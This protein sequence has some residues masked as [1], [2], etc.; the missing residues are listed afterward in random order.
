MNN[1]EKP[2]TN[3]TGASEYGADDVAEADT[4][5]LMTTDE[6]NLKASVSLDTVTHL[7]DAF[8]N[9]D[10]LPPHYHPSIPQEMLDPAFTQTAPL[11]KLWPLAVLVFYSEYIYLLLYV[12][13]YT[14]MCT[15]LISKPFG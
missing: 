9:M 14:S 1:E 15:Q 5:L 10:E 4:G 2:T 12:C 13:L 8:M 3:G 6:Y 11:L 7:K